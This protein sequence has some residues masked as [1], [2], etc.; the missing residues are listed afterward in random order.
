MYFVKIKESYILE[1]QIEYDFL[2]I[3]NIYWQ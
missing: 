2:C 3:F 1:Q